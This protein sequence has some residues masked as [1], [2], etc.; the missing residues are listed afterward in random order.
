MSRPD[1]DTLLDKIQRDEAKARRGRLKVFFGASAGV[2]K[3]FGML[4][5]ARRL[6]DDGLDVVVGIVETHGRVETEALLEGLEVLPLQKLDYRD[7]TLGEFDLDAALERK[8]QLLLVDELAHSNVSGARHAKRWQ[9]VHELLDAGIDVFTT[10]NVQHLESLNDIVG[11]ITGIRVWETVPDRV[12]DLADDVTLVDLPADDLLDRLR[13]GKVYLPQQAERAIQNFFR[14]GNL[15]ALRELALRRTADRVDAQMREYR[16]DRSIDRVWQTR[17][18]VLVCVG[19]GPESSALV[20]A[21]ARLASSLRADWIAVYVET[22]QLQRLPENLRERTL[23]ALKL[24][25]DLGGETATLD[26]DDAAVTLV[27]YAHLRNVSKLIVG[28][29][30]L[31]RFWHR[32]RRPVGER[33]AKMAGDLD[34]TRIGV[35]VQ[36]LREDAAAMRRANWP[37]WAAGDERHSHPRNYLGAAAIC[38]VVTLLAT[39]LARR[40]DQT[41]LEMLYLLGVVFAAFRLGRGP[42][43]LLSFLSV[44]AFDF[45]FVPPKMSFSVS[46]TQYLLT[47]AGMLITSLVISHLTS[48]LR[49]QVRVAS[50]RERRSSAMYEIA[51]ELAA[52]LTTEQIVEIGARHVSELFRAHVAI[53]LPDSDEKVRQP[54]DDPNPVS[55]L[56]NA[57]IDIDVAQWVYDQQ[58]RAGRGTDTLPAGNALYLPLKAPMRTRGV[59]ALES[60]NFGTLA[61]PEQ[62]RMLD[63]FAAQIAL[64]LERVHYVDIA[65]DALVDMESER[66]RNSL[67]SAISHDLRT[68]LTALVGF[69]SVL[70]QSRDRLDPAQAPLLD[71]IHDE[72]LRMTGLVTNL[73]DMARLQAGRVRLNRDWTMIEEVIGAALRNARHTLAAHP[74]SVR[75]PPELPLVQIDSVLIERVFANLF[76]NAA[77]YTPPGTPLIVGAAVIEAGGKPMLRVH[78]DDEGPGLLPGSESRVFD[79][80]TRGEKE[81]AKPGIGLGLAICRAIVEAHGGTIGASNRP[82]LSANGVPV[83]GAVAGARFWFTLP[84]DTPPPPP[85]VEFE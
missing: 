52:A 41:N 75:L 5:A 71:A 19:P 11:Q 15:I 72:A 39:V 28:G 12:F 73:L 67:L 27:D 21:A 68:P 13:E 43:I 74:A 48:S 59:L 17:E 33:I 35:D 83:E 53:L 32:L 4:Q 66:L 34:V 10:V 25:Q 42:G 22:P 79:K 44:A 64:A 55:M 65:R 78:V 62:Q 54:L 31:E 16:A 14:K 50:L 51:R 77:K 84:I 3:T 18:R 69:A 45:F 29:T 70:A 63:A 81:S 61:V 24:A 57:A 46:D 85:E 80:F 60:E 76:E 6:H 47:F 49:R 37:A 40:F 58:K 1:P 9:D 82:L 36:P 20:R 26:G 8:P 30:Q 38:A 23:R 2:G 56:P 7:R